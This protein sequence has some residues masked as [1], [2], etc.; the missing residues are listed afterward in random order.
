MSNGSFGHQP[1]H[2]I[3]SVWVGQLN[4]LPSV[5]RQ[6]YNQPLAW[7]IIPLWWWWPSASICLFHADLICVWPRLSPPSRRPPGAL[8]CVVVWSEWTFKALFV[9]GII[10]IIIIIGT[11]QITYAYLLDVS[12]QSSYLPFPISHPESSS[13]SS[14]AKGYEM[15]MEPLKNMWCVCNVI[16]I[17]SSSRTRFLL[18]TEKKP[19]TSFP[20]IM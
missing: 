2:L 10:I 13:L 19:V 12:R 7:I 5:E 20:V 16:R 1:Q 8:H 11:A 14:E 15:T 18:L 17:F 4:P 3:C 9:V 6:S